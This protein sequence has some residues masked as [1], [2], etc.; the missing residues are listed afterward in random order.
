MNTPQGTARERQKAR[1]QQEAQW[2][3]QDAAPY[4]LAACQAILLLRDCH[5]SCRPLGWGPLPLPCAHEM[6]LAAIAKAKGETP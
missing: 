2:R 6:L 5:C 1:E 3:L 4:L